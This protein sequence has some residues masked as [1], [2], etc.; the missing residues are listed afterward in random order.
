[1]GEHL[2]KHDGDP[3]FDQQ[4]EPLPEETHG[5]METS[6]RTL[7]GLIAKGELPEGVT[8]S[9]IEHKG[10]EFTKAEVD[11]IYDFLIKSFEGEEMMDKMQTEIGL[12]NGIVDYHG[13]RDAEGNLVSLMCSQ[14]IETETDAGGSELS[15]IV[16][17]VANREGYKGKSLVKEVAAVALSDLLN[18]AKQE[19]KS[20]KALLGEAEL[21]DEDEVRREKAFNRYAGMRRVHGKGKNG[22]LSEAL[23]EAPP[24]EE[25]TTGEPAHFMVRLLDGRN[26]ISKEEYMQFVRAL[27][28]QYT[29]EEYFTSEYVAF[30]E[31]G[32]PEDYP[33]EAVEK[34]RQQYVRIISRIQKKIEKNIKRFQGDLIL[35]SEREKRK[36]E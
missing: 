15:M 23:Y 20:I 19:Q 31:G 13:A 10:G 21:G 16:W 9:K 3:T 29:R 7:E 11:E 22:K 33:A 2:N 5:K 25:F 8:V 4:P 17:Y 1:M 28:A 18:K 14:I 26:S 30:T 32:E 34:Y 24:E 12:V 27:H 6:W 36:G 35:L